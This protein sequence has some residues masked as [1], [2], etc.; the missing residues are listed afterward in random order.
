[1]KVA[2]ITDTHFGA[3]NDSD[4][5]A[6]FF[7][8]FYSEVFFPYLKKNNIKE[9]IHLGDA[10]D[11]RKY[12]NFNSLMRCK[13][14][15][16]DGIKK[17]K[18][19]LHQ[20]IGNHDTYFKNTNNV[21]SPSLLLGEYEDCITLYPEPVEAKI[22]NL[23][24]LM[25]PWICPDNTEN[26]MHLINN[27]SASVLM[28]HLELDGFEMHR[29]AF[30]SGGL[31][32]SLFS[33]FD[34]VMSGH[35]HHR[36]SNRNIHYLGCPYEMSWSDYNDPKGFHIFDT[37]TCAL[38]FVENPL[39]LFQ[40]VKY[41]DTTWNLDTINNFDFSNLKDTYVKVIV[42]N[43]GNPYWFELFVNKI[44]KTNP[45]DIQ[46]VD[47]N[48]NMD[49]IDDKEILENIDDTLTILN[50]SIEHVSLE[51]DKTKLNDLFKNL[52]N[53]AIQLI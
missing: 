16:Y 19:K 42:I 40:K 6:N 12:I 9:V 2:L 15:F 49:L 45:A 8:K 53:E 1:M 43:K 33:K 25:M 35:F 23:K 14:Y 26:A 31:E 21:N 48:L 32:A 39:V 38:E 11:R 44:E 24:I 50:K 5:L 46:I 13:Q 3:R 41:N 7:D 30:H 51:V 18:L 4:I 22:G 52:Y 20:I 29:G 28:G 27:S 34:M 17:N 36:S 47:D 37:K 10:F